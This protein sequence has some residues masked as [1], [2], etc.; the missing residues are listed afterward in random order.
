MTIDNLIFINGGTYANIKKALRQ[1]MKDYSDDLP[2]DLT[3]ELYKNGR[4]RHIIKADE[5]LDNWFFYFLVNYLNFPEGIEPR[6]QIEG[7][8]TGKNNDVLKNEKM[9][10][11]ISPYDE[12][13][14]NVYVTTSSNKNYKI[15]FAVEITEADETKPYLLP[16]NQHFVNPELLRIKKGE[17]SREQEE[18]S[19][20]STEK[21][22]NI[23][24]T[25]VFFAFIINLLIPKFPNG[26]IIF[27]DSTA[28]LFLCVGVWFFIDTGILKSNST[29]LKCL[30]IAIGCLFYYFFIVKNLIF[31]PLI[32]PSLF[33]LTILI[34]QRPSRSLFK[35]IFKR[36][37]ET[38]FH[39]KI[40]DFIYSLILFVGSILLIGLIINAAK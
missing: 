25:I 14:D 8:T 20:K 11:Y 4:G 18:K 21:R 23:I 12:D 40:T 34:I 16:S 28:I 26:I 22:L 3:F 5:R 17:I 24:S 32:F 1:W 19:K 6:V 13:G 31:E 2:D 35:A 10:V 38:N 29:Y 9:L 33:P 36:E 27:K 39:G 37:P 7:F 30:L 15:D